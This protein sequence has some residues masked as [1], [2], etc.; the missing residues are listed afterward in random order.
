MEEKKVFGETEQETE[1]SRNEQ[2]TVEIS[3]ESR[4]RNEQ[5]ARVVTAVFAARLDPTVEELDDIKTAVSEAVTNAII[6]GYENRKGIVH[7]K[8][9]IRDRILSVEVRD[10]GVG[11]EDVKRAMEPLYTSK[12]SRERSGMG[13]SFM[14]AFMDKVEV[15]SAPG[16]GTVVTMEKEL[17]RRK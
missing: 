17:G 4:S 10:D 6:H 16:A 11:I 1:W 12:P 7:M 9:T 8:L 3:F 15:E 14:E 13:F 2:E 5:F